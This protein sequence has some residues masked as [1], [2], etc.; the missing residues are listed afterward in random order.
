MYISVTSSLE[1]N[2]RIVLPGAISYILGEWLWSASCSPTCLHENADS[3][4]PI[5]WSKMIKRGR[6]QPHTHST[7]ILIVL[8][9]WEATGVISLKDQKGDPNSPCTVIWVLPALHCNLPFYFTCLVNI[10]IGLDMKQWLITITDFTQIM[11]L[12]LSDDRRW[13]TGLLEPGIVNS[14]TSWGQ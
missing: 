6:Y 1:K 14:L 5:I 8:L 2:F 4:Q 10:F 11:W 13:K 3:R 9:S 7:E 12:V